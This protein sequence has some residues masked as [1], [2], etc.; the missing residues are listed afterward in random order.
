MLLNYQMSK[1]INKL[2]SNLSNS[3]ASINKQKS[4]LDYSELI[5]KYH[6]N[7]VLLIDK[8]KLTKQFIRVGT[9]PKFKKREFS[10]LNQEEI[11]DYNSKLQELRSRYLETVLIT[12]LTI[13]KLNR[14][15]KIIPI[16]LPLIR[17]RE[18]KTWFK[19]WNALRKEKRYTELLEVLQKD[20]EVILIPVNRKKDEFQ[21][22]VV[23]IDYGPKYPIH[24]T[25]DEVC[26]F[27]SP[28][29]YFPP[30]KDYR[31][32]LQLN[33]GLHLEPRLVRIRRH[34]QCITIP[35]EFI[36]SLMKYPAEVT[37]EFITQYGVFS[38]MPKYAIFQV[39][40]IS[41]GQRFI[42]KDTFTASR[43]FNLK[44][45]TTILVDA[46]TSDFKRFL[47]TY[48]PKNHNLLIFSKGE[49]DEIYSINMVD[50]HLSLMS[51]KEEKEI[52]TFIRIYLLLDLLFNSVNNSGKADI[53]KFFKGILEYDKE[54]LNSIHTTNDFENILAGQLTNQEYMIKSDVVSRIYQTFRQFNH[55][56][57]LNPS[58][59]IIEGDTLIQTIANRNDTFMGVFLILL[60]IAITKSHELSNITLVLDDPQINMVLS[61]KDVYSHFSEFISSLQGLRVIIHQSKKL[62]SPTFSALPQLILNTMDDERRV[63]KFMVGN[64]SMEIFPMELN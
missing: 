53:I 23:L 56:Q 35:E 49:W 14:I 17:R 3:I 29:Q 34:N 18:K 7:G 41:F 40:N 21:I 43:Y 55:R 24:T 16:R 6:K 33:S 39:P 13:W 26:S 62:S 64:R 11:S 31:Q 10:I 63:S 20:V 19:K 44:E 12:R 9:L 61:N 32:I 25:D 54:I 46:S 57:M 60:R 1:K 27:T 58:E 4:I 47:K 48:S 5:Y 28:L 22:V 38:P 45:G 30:L 2:F 59:F 42:N 15:K 51:L 52:Q 36:S 50:I 8:K 37:N